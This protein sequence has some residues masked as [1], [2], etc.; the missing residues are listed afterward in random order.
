[1]GGISFNLPEYKATESQPHMEAFTI[2]K[3]IA[4][5]ARGATQFFHLEFLRPYSLAV[6]DVA[7]VKKDG[8]QLKHGLEL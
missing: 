7:V 3:H 8:A 4:R 2:F 6:L 5:I 1:M